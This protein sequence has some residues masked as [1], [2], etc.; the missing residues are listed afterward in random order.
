MS[1]RML[2]TPLDML[3]TPNAKPLSCGAFENLFQ[4]LLY[5]SVYVSLVMFVSPLIIYFY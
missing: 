2:S 5:F 4:R 1:L 3:S